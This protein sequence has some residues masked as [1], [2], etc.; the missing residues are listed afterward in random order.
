MADEQETFLQRWAR[1]KSE[2]RERTSSDSSPAQPS[3]D[4]AADSPSPTAAAAVVPPEQLPS[5][6]DLTKDSDFTAFLKEGVPEE[7]KRLALRKL[8][9]S[10]PVFANLDG[11]VEYGEDF[12]APFRNPG[13]VA[14]LFR[15]GQGMP[16]REESSDAEA[17]ERADLNSES[18]GG[19]QQTPSEEVEPSLDEDKVMNS[20]DVDP[21]ADG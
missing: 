5:I 7:L 3:K 8:W 14:T 21:T 4:E 6:D 1:R 11:L 13:P 10:D 17:E 18:Q 12:G 20:S 16:G 2:R 19:E 9:R 15:L